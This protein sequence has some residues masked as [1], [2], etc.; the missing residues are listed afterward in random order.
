MLTSHGSYMYQNELAIAIFLF[1]KIKLCSIAL[2]STENL[3]A[4][5]FSFSN[6]MERKTFLSY[7]L[8]T[9]EQFRNFGNFEPPRTMRKDYFK[10]NTFL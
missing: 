4:V 2:M 8:E 6:F 7:S 10:R 5:L 3:V 1:T 9:Y